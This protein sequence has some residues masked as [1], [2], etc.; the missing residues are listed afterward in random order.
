MATPDQRLTRLANQGL[1]EVRHPDG[2]RRVRQFARGLNEKPCKLAKIKSVGECWL[3]WSVGIAGNK[4][5]CEWTPQETGPSSTYGRRRPIYE[6]LAHMVRMR[7][8]PA[9]AIRLIDIEYPGLGLTKIAASL[10]RR[11]LEGTLPAAW[12]LNM[13]A[14]ARPTRRVQ[15]G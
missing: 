11:S 13:P 5:A 9:A 4:A 10:R 7:K 15:G 6:T 8:S 1:E 12:G 14:V 3:E 2:R